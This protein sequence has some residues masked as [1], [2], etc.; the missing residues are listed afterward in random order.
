MHA[1]EGPCS[2]DGY[3]VD[4]GPKAE[5]VPVLGTITFEEYLKPSANELVKGDTLMHVLKNGKCGQLSIA[6]SLVSTAKA[7]MS[8]KV[9]P[10]SDDGYTIDNGPK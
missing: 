1:V 3:T 5:T 4:N 7:L 9:G 10:C 6:D 2:D 8:A